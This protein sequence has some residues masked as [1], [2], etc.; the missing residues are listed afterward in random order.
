MAT[1]LD[2]GRV[3]EEGEVLGYIVVVA[4]WWNGTNG[5]YKDESVG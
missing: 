3:R 4:L 2:L 1:V 5:N